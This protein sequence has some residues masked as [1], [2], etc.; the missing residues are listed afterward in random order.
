MNRYRVKL[1]CTADPRSDEQKAL[2]GP[3]C[4]RVA[5]ARLWLIAQNNPKVVPM[6]RKVQ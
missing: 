5:L 3:L 6:A 4:R 1:R 2:E